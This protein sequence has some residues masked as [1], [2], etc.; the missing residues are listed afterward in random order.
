MIV[1]D[2]MLRSFG[3]LAAAVAVAAAVATAMP[4]TA[5]PEP[6]PS[7]PAPSPAPES[8]PQSAPPS[9]A[10]APSA[11]PPAAPPSAPAAPTGPG[12]SEA[13]AAPPARSA[14]G[15]D[16]NAARAVL[17]QLV[18]FWRVAGRSFDGRGQ[19]T[20]DLSGSA[21]YSWTLGG[22]FLGGEQVLTD[23]REMVQWLD[24]LGFNAV[25]QN[26]SR[27]LLSDRDAANYCSIGLWDERSRLLTF[28]TD[29]VRGPD[30][31]DRRIRSTL[32]LSNADRPAWEL[33]YLVGSG[34]DEREVASVK[35]VL[36]RTAAPAGTPAPSGPLIPGAPG[37]AAP[38]SSSPFGPGP[39][40]PA[41][42]Q[43]RLD[44]V[45]RQRQQMQQQIEDMRQQ[46]RTM[47]NTMR[48]ITQP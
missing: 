6:V 42:V 41:Q 1:R 35:L 7:E 34:A 25:T 23:G 45:L 8:A 31:T 11:A 37:Q 16:E 12:A 33:V 3:A 36:T 26:F 13:P 17:G 21:A 27:T 44:S 19:P 43:D 22:L 48:R 29:P 47:S 40:S 5:S 24:L 32:V 20:G 15:L 39:M 30:G 2:T 9:S 46:M 18:G 28:I 10:P 14:T 4:S 38:R